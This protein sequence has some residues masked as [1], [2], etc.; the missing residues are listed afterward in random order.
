MN[1][2]YEKE[3]GRIFNLIDPK[4]QSDVARIIADDNRK[5][6]GSP[7][8]EAISFIINQDQISPV[9]EHDI[10]IPSLDTDIEV[11]GEDTP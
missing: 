4:D 3:V 8:L 6:N 7:I 2:L 1:M 10:N 11:S 5:G 9:P